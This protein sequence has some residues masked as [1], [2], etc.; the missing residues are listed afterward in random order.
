MDRRGGPGTAVD[1][2]RPGRGDG[3]DLATVPGIQESLLRDLR[4][5][6]TFLPQAT[7]LPRGM[8]AR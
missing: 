7:A 8:P 3:V 2:G 6:V 4:F 1:G 5:W